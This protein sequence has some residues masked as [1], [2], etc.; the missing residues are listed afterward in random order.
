MA[1]GIQLRSTLSRSVLPDVAEEQLIY[2]LLEVSAHGVP[3]TMPKLPLNLCLV[4]DRSSSMRGERLQQVK[5]AAYRIVDMLGEDDYFSL[6]TFNDRADVVISAQRARN[7]NDLKRLIGGVEAA[8]GT[9]MATGMALGLQEI[10]RT[11]L[12][13]GVSRLMLLTDGRTYGDE[14]RCVDI[15]RRAQGRGVGLTALGI[16]NEWNED[17]LET[18]AA[19]ENS[20]TQY[21]TSSGEIAQIFT[22]EVKRMHSVFAQDVQLR[23]EVRPGAMLRSL[24]RVRPFIA[25]VQAIEE[26]DRVWAANLGDWPGSDPQ[27]FLLEV[28]VPPLAVGDHPLLRLTLRYSLPGMNLMNQEGHLVLRVGVRP[29]A[30]VAYDVDITVKHWLERLVAYRLQAGAWQDM[31][32]GRIEE[33]TRRLQM[34]G[35]RLFEAGDVELAH[36][37]QEE[38]TR[39]L[40]SGQ[41]SAEGRKRIK[42]GTRGLMSGGEAH[43]REA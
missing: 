23:A 11:M 26:K 14:G 13:R 16:G 10:Q 4:V 20:R 35:T 1:P 17:L 31:E 22:D 9:E 12:G 21:I 27:A 34:A 5:D 37:V 40:R 24:D 29:A 7:K 25:T 38:A 30:S 43:E 19:R 15:A 2:V 8:G 3:T 18:M 6:V 32:A 39:L 42:Y 41:T 33:A 36:T 28:V